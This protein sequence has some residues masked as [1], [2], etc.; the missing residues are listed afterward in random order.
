MRL[1]PLARFAGPLVFA[2]L[3]GPVAFAQPASSPA[4]RTGG[5]IEIR[6]VTRLVPAN[7]RPILLEVNKGTL[8]RLSQPA[9]T[10]FVANPDIADVQ[11]KSPKLIYLTAKSPGETVIYAVDASE[12]VLLNAP[13]RVSL[14]LS[15]LR[16]N[17]QRLVPGS[18]I[19][20][21]S[22]GNNL[23]LTGSV[24]DAA[25]AERAVALA[26]SIVGEVK[27]GQVINRMSIATP[28]QVDLRVLIAEVDKTVLKQIGVDWSKLAGEVTF[29]TMN[30]V[31]PLVN[32]LTIGQ[33]IGNATTATIEAL[34]T[35]GYLTVLAQPDLIAVS[36]QTAQFLAGGE[37]PVPIVQSTSTTV[38]APA[39]SIQ[40]QPFG[41]QLSFT[42]T[43]L[44]ANHLSLRVA[45]QVSQ[46]STQGEVSIS[47]FVI[48]ALTVRSA[49]TTLDLASGQSFALAGLLMH[50][51]TQ[52][53]SKVPWI[54]DIPILGALFRSNK[55]QND[56]TEL[57]IL[58][59]PYLVRPS[60]QPMASPVAGWQA[61]NDAQQVFMSDWYRQKL[62][63][64]PQGPVGA[65]GRG[66]IGPG[67]FQLN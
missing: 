60:T 19:S 47:G 45:P 46:L 31:T 41:V 28:N 23:V 7:G 57:V 38:G 55:F 8:I 65:G 14:D 33:A 12:N 10:V 17:L 11:V 21:D 49:Q 62:P 52:D 1:L 39:I 37:F 50:N 22:V 29:T 56:E 58:V 61:P 32:S 42:P 53:I 64:P 15:S 24:A 67:G 18:L 43:V 35:E 16:R 30:N 44:D 25:Q 48:P 5:G 27:G 3:V 6:D 63:G 26:N 59:T 36:G 51:T 54:G 34:E 20:T 13:I 2:A 66:L 40:F 4:A 9:S